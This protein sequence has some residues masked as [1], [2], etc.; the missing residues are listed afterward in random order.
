MDPAGRDE[1]VRALTAE[2]LQASDILLVYFVG[3]GLV[4]QDLYLATAATD[5]RWQTLVATSVAFRDVRQVLKNRKAN[6]TIVILD[7]CYAGRAQSP[8]TPAAAD[9]F[10]RV[11]LGGTYLLTA[12]S[13]SEQAMAPPGEQYTAFSGEL[14]SL[15]R[16]GDRT[17]LPQ[18]TLEAVYALLRRRLLERGL[19]GPQR[20]LSGQAGQLILADNPS[21]IAVTPTR[22]P[23]ALGTAG[24]ADH[25]CP[26]RGLESYTEDDTRYFF[27]RGQTLADLLAHIDAL[28]EVGGPVLVSGLSGVGKSSLLQAGLVPAVAR[29]ELTASGSNQWLRAVIR[30]REYPLSELATVLSPLTE[31]PAEVV[32][33]NLQRAPEYAAAT[34]AGHLGL[35]PAAGGLLLIV[36][37]FEEVFT[38]CRDEFERRAFIT[39]L[40][41]LSTWPVLVVLAIRADFVPYCHPYTALRESIQHR[42]FLVAPMTEHQ[43]RSAIADPA[44]AVGLQL[45]HGLVDR[46]L[47]DLNA[48]VSPGHNADQSS[49]QP[50]GPKLGS[51]AGNL[52]LL[53]FSLQLTWEY[54]DQNMLTLAGYQRTG[55]VWDAVATRAQAAFSQLDTAAKAAAR[56]MF[57][58]MVQVSFDAEDTRRTL[59][60]AE[61][62][63]GPD[64]ASMHRA[65]T[66]FASSRLVTVDGDTAQIAHDALLKA[67]PQLRTWITED[68]LGILERQ[69]LSI[70]SEDWAQ[71]GREKSMLYRGARL[72]IAEQAARAV[73][74]SATAAGFLDAARRDR[75]RNRWIS[76]GLRSAL[77]LLTV[78]ALVVAFVAVRAQQRANTIAAENVAARLI[79]DAQQ[80]FGSG[81]AGSQR[82]AVL[83]T[84]A[85]NKLAP[86]VSDAGV[87]AAQFRTQFVTRILDLDARAICGTAVSPDGRWVVTGDVRSE[88]RLWDTTT[89][90]AHTMPPT[91]TVVNCELAV[92]ADGHRVV[93]NGGLGHPVRLWDTTTDAIR[94]LPNTE[95][96]MADQVTITPDG[97]W[98]LAVN[99]GDWPELWDTTTNT[100]TRAPVT[101][102]PVWPRTASIS[103]DG[104]WVAFGTAGGGIELWDV[105]A[106]VIRTSPHTAII[107]NSAQDITAIAVNGN[108]LWV[109]AGDTSGA[110]CMWDVASN[111][112]RSMANPGK[113]EISGI[114]VSADG[115]RVAI[116]DKTA[117][118]REWNTQSD[119]SIA[120][121]AVENANRSPQPVVVFGSDQRIISS[122][123]DGIVRAWP[124]EAPSTSIAD[125]LT[126][127]NTQWDIASNG[128]WVAIRDA[129]SDI[130]LWNSAT[131][132]TRTITRPDF[133]I[134]GS[135]TVSDDGKWLAATTGTYPHPQLINLWSTTSEIHL[136]MPTSLEY[137]DIRLAISGDGRQIAVGTNDSSGEIQIW[138]TSSDTVRMLARPG[139]YLP[140]DGSHA[141]DSVGISRDGR[142][143]A[144]GENGGAVYLWDLWTNAEMVMPTP[145][146]ASIDGLAISPDGRWVASGDFAGTVRLW[147]TSTHAVRTMSTA[148]LPDTGGYNAPY[149]AVSDDGQWIAAEVGGSIRMW[150]TDPNQTVA[151]PVSWVGPSPD[152]MAA[153]D[154]KAKSLV[155]ASNTGKVRSIPIIPDGAKK[156]CSIL[157]NPITLTEWESWVSRTSDP[158]PLC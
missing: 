114:A 75:T 155:L 38:N 141:I 151:V 72:T 36:D 33:E 19:P 137:G 120:L 127:R 144:A 106:N 2:S 68:W 81:D 143:V 82:R 22:S 10:G 140:V 70:D 16:H 99:G 47:Q 43:L 146:T 5:D 31:D 59:T 48:L 118:L 41:E 52:P 20:H 152:V 66:V 89:G 71:R 40:C 24:D 101:D 98:V 145:G 37:Q 27:G 130:R 153:F 60:V 67:W 138:N 42:Q 135:T 78:V 15:L 123:D 83:E 105:A 44:Q 113:A 3:H 30:P 88:V 57:M 84:L 63:C 116:G 87:L 23:T 93:V 128:Q 109:A 21:S 115:Q 18:I 79:G 9:A 14:I 117:D 103:P 28:D 29:G 102:T 49:R 17:A 46:L 8:I 86:Q 97:R 53:S 80:Q 54:R 4:D 12:A 126:P 76:V 139:G 125:G 35:S 96:S 158:V 69:R 131:G 111:S 25:P 90:Q 133:G 74:V 62:M 129:S 39:A 119:T 7:C 55:G 107:G 6:S 136:V 157:T 45:E 73:A 154:S 11:W 108:G 100:T 77:V 1:V 132:T 112:I 91:N 148:G 95:I 58:R 134:M 94:A 142:W 124:A 147:D 156:M 64:P 32:R 85:A 51:P 110:V 104:R 65:L 56:T 150:S 34:A 50:N 121:P 122:D 26:Y 92:S 61:L 149:I 13:G